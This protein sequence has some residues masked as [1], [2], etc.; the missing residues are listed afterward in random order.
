MDEFIVLWNISFAAAAVVLLG[1]AI[2]SHRFNDGIVIKVGLGCMTLGFAVTAHALS[3]GLDCADLRM[4]ARA[5]ALVN[6]GALTV[7]GGYLLRTRAGRVKKRR[8]TD[9]AEFDDHAS[10]RPEA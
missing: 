7:A 2:L 6:I 8:K 4:L 9:W 5:I 3:N 1:W 10:F